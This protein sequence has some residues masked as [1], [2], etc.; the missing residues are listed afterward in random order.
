MS[1]KHC[2]RGKAKFSHPCARHSSC[3]VDYLW[4]P[5]NCHYCAA[6]FKAADA[7]EIPNVE[8]DQLK[9]ITRRIRDNL[10][11]Q[12][13]GMS[14]TIFA[15]ESSLQKF[16]RPWLNPTLLVQGPESNLEQDS[17]PSPHIPPFPNSSVS[18]SAVDLTDLVKNATS[19]MSDLEE[20]ATNSVVI[21][22]NPDLSTSSAPVTRCLEQD[23]NNRVNS[24]V[25]SCS[26]SSSSNNSHT[27]ADHFSAP[28]RL[29]PSLAAPAV[30]NISEPSGSL[31]QVGHPLPLS[32]PEVLALQAK[33]ERLEQLQGVYT[34]EIS[35]YFVRSP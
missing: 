7:S 27:S 4:E 6:L 30:Q 32:S 3:V 24:M 9:H 5:V 16:H 15:S 12:L 1:C 13:F 21:P 10:P 29:A 33:V 26:S 34:L 14:N 28:N 2:D 23:S 20:V 22:S 31:R 18:R 25:P 35:L 19:G 11:L 8:S 17:T